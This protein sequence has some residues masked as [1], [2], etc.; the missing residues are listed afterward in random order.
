MQQL[1]SG[2]RCCC[3]GTVPGGEFFWKKIFLESWI[4]A[5]FL[6]CL[7]KI[8]LESPGPK[9][10]DA[11]FICFEEEFFGKPG[12]RS[13]FFLLKNMQQLTSG[14]AAPKKNFLESPVPSG[15]MHSFCWV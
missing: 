3:H 11:H 7:Y 15:S 8:F 1:T 13:V 12:S 5:Q 4:N 10:I 14:R 2:M 6:F 9:W